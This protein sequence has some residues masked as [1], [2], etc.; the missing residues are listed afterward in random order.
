MAVDTVDKYGNTRHRVPKR[1]GEAFFVASSFL[2]VFPKQ[3]GG[4]PSVDF[5]RL[6]LFRVWPCS[7]FCKY[8][9]L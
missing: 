6:S 1:G 5:V 2:L 8:T 3:S 9:N 7:L 4:F